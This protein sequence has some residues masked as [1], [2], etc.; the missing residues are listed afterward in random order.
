M[1]VQYRRTFFS[2][3]FDQQLLESMD[4][5]PTHRCRGRIE[6]GRAET[7]AVSIVYREAWAAGGKL[8]TAFQAQENPQSSGLLSP[9]CAGLDL[10][11]VLVASH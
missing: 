5:E 9:S 11:T 6:Y 2:N 8:G 4:V 3:I 7:C 10:N 1:H